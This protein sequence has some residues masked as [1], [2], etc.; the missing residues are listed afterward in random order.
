MSKGIT[1]FYKG[2]ETVNRVSYDLSTN[3]EVPAKSALV[4]R[5]W[6]QPISYTD[7]TTENPLKFTFPTTS[8]LVS[9]SLY[10]R[11]AETT[12]TTKK[13][14]VGTA[15]ADSGTPNVIF[16]QIDVSTTGLKGI[17]STL[18]AAITVGGSPF[19]YTAQGSQVVTVTGGTVSSITL[20][21]GGTASASLGTA[22]S[23]FV[24]DQDILTVTYTGLPTMLS[25]PV[26]DP[27]YFYL[28]GG[29]R[30]SWTPASANFAS[31]VAEILVEY[32]VFDDITLP[33]NENTNII[34]GPSD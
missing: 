33:L 18:P 4:M 21:R 23:F 29:K 28:A 10:V 3:Q 34:M 12:G 24:A 6:S 16:N 27:E 26:P 13:I 17:S 19:A 15:T 7:G 20:S 1:A 31:L 22:G 11:T 2:M 9:A 25:F 8:I 32:L 30:L 5:E 14:N